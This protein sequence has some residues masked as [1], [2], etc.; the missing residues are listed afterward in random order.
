MSKS[1]SGMQP[2]E[3]L[4]LDNEDLYLFF[5]SGNGVL[6]LQPTEEDWYRTAETPVDIILNVGNETDRHHFYVPQEPASPLACTDKYQFCRMTSKDNRT[7]GPL[8]SFLDAVV[9]AASLFDSSYAQQV[10]V[11]TQAINITTPLEARWLYFMTI[12]RASPRR[13]NDII[14]RLGPTALQSQRTLT[15][16]FQ[17]PLEKTQWQLDVIHWWDISRAATQAAFINAVYGPT[18]PAILL[19]RNNFTAPFTQL[20]DSQVCSSLLLSY[21]ILSYSQLLVVT[22]PFCFR[23]NIIILENPKH[24][25]RIPERLRPLFHIHSWHPDCTNFLPPGANICLLP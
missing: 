21:Y 6:F 7:C 17:G 10:K 12:F 15:N 24:S 20:C 22:M 13:V 11:G 8:T 2:I 14:R 3:S 1:T 23:A 9:G 19:S 16:S 4:R 5:L 25:L 18:D